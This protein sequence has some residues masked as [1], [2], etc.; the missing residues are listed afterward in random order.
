MEELSRILR[1]IL[2]RIPYQVFLK[3]ELD[4]MDLDQNRLGQMIHG[5]LPF[6][7]DTEIRNMLESLKHFLNEYNE[8]LGNRRDDTTLSVF[9]AVFRFSEGM[10]VRRNNKVMVRYERILRWRVITKD[11]SEDIFTA[12]FLARTD[13]R[14]GIYCQDFT[15]PFVIS[16]NN[17]QLKRM[18]EKGLA[19]NHF[20]LWGSAPY[21]HLSW[22]WLMN[23]MT[24]VEQGREMDLLT[25][26]IRTVNIS[27]GNSAYD[28]DMTKDCLYAS[29]IRL[30]LYSVLAD[31]P[32]DFGNYYIEWH[33]LQP[34]IQ[35]FQ[36]PVQVDKNTVKEIGILNLLRNLDNGLMSEYFFSLRKILKKNVDFGPLLDSKRGLRV[37][38]FL[39]YALK[40]QE[41]ICLQDCRD[42]FSDAEYKYLFN[43]KTYRKILLYL[44]EYDL[45]C[46]HLDQI[47]DAMDRIRRNKRETK[48]DYILDSV[49]FHSYYEN[50]TNY[51]LSGE[52]WF[53]YEM[54]RH[55]EIRDQLFTPQMYNL[56]YVY[57]LIKEKFHGEM[58]QSNDW[59]GF[60]NFS[61]Y[62]R[63]SG[64]FS[65][66]ELERLKVKMAV[67]S[68]LEQNVQRLELRI[69]P[70]DSAKENY[71][72]IQFLDQAIGIGDRKKDLYCFVL[73]FIKR[74]DDTDAD[75]PVCNCRHSALRVDIAKKTMALLEFR[76]LYPE[77]AARVMGIDAAAQ[78]IG[79]RPEV[80]AQA[81]RTLRNDTSFVYSEKGF[82]KL[83]QLR[84]TYHVGED[85]LDV[86]DGL[87]AIDEAILFLNLD[88]GDRLGHALALGISVSDW[89][90]SKQN[91]IWISKQDYLDNIVWLYHTLIRYNIL[92]MDN[93]K[94]R[95]ENEYIRYF[96]EIYGQNMNK[97]FVDAIYSAAK[98]TLNRN[99]MAF[100]I[101]A[102]FDAWKLRGDAP[103]LY[104]K[105]FY[106][107]SEVF[108]SLFDRNAVNY[109]FPDNFDVRKKCQ[110]SMIYYYYH[111]DKKVREAGQKRINIKVNYEY[112]KGV[113]L[114]QKAMQSEI[115]KRG[116]GIEANP[117]SNVSIGTFSIYDEHP[118]IRLF[119]S[120]L[121]INDAEL[122]ECP[123]L[124][125]SINTD[126][127]GI[128]GTK[129]EN[130]YALVARALEKKTDENGEYLYSKAMIYDWLDKIREMGLKQSFLSNR[131]IL[132][133]MNDKDDINIHSRLFKVSAN[134]QLDI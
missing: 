57:I 14:S 113:E 65:T 6:Y 18:T 30:Y 76:D 82:I 32:L 110:I 115:A 50:E 95:I 1:V 80:F 90:K 96:D 60:E 93:L 101:H 31:I 2:K 48:Y 39:E 66:E 117:S 131:G 40:N 116:I 20:H 128:F 84:V 9:D 123:Q 86:V 25:Q 127:Q 15:W 98:N 23:H 37:C 106:N 69:T 78:E 107:D 24:E 38:D 81:F 4:C 83:P 124:W 16:H 71:E 36:S 44:D 34:W 62:Q 108:L 103:Q 12:A 54:F 77:T 28:N 119:N 21:F 58:V 97:E 53:L 89:Y 92:G 29:L 126:D 3:G 87:R 27:V 11:I 73:H 64:Y 45:M 133:E 112:I 132:S 49:G 129:L 111:F 79:C 68:C 19:D 102:Y 109:L 52:R 85:F 47:Q 72:E 22:M 56:F 125:I 5:Y 63:N 122:Q 61:I 75:R 33:E 121:T 91:H 7:S 67:V 130:E 100:D 104:R 35:K 114:V 74:Q 105:G 43:H 88:C 59:V 70:K 118:L 17:A 46:S 55:I 26:N 120:G 99:G 42:L 41:Y 13:M 94:N 134:A 51:V 8:F 10:L